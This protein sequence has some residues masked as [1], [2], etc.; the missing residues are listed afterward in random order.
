MKEEII[1]IVKRCGDIHAE[2]KG[3]KGTQCIDV[4]QFINALGVPSRTLK[5]EYFQSSKNTSLPFSAKNRRQRRAYIFCFG[6][7][8]EPIKHPLVNLRSLTGFLVAVLNGCRSGNR[9]A[10]TAKIMLAPKAAPRP[11]APRA[12]FCGSYLIRSLTKPES[13]LMPGPMVVDTAMVLK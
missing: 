4:I 13:I 8:V 12:A 1:V 2:V 11:L 3:V 5:G 10:C 9:S 6:M 7:P